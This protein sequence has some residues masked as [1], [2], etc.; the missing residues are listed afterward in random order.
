[1]QGDV[2]R[3]PYLS[4]PG[5]RIPMEGGLPRLVPIPPST[6]YHAPE[7]GR[8]MRARFV[9]TI[10][11]TPMPDAGFPL[12]LSAHGTGGAAYNF[13]GEHNF[14]GWA[15]R[16][17]IAVVSTDQPLHGGADEQGARPGS[18]EPFVLRIGIFPIP[19]GS[20]KHVGELAFYNPLHPGAARDNLRQAAVD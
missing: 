6:K 7:C 9:L 4:S 18:R 3:A 20:G 12:L 15:A 14:A 5:G 16:H 10:P 1:F 19:L 17:G 2:E 8:L 13:R 11:S